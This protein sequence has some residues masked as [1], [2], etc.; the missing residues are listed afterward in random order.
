MTADNT[1]DCKFVQS[2]PRGRDPN[3]PEGWPYGYT[4]T[5]EFYFD[6]VFAYKEY[7][8]Y[9]S[10]EMKVEGAYGLEVFIE[11]GHTRYHAEQNCKDPLN[12]VVV[13]GDNE[14]V[15]FAGRYMVKLYRNCDKTGQPLY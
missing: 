14:V 4:H 10:H 3:E 12:W 5:L 11:K 6:G 15:S 8:H 2:P 13:G 7:I 9:G 1:N